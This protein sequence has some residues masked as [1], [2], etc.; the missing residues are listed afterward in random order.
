VERGMWDRSGA[1]SGIVFVV[2]FVIGFLIIG[3]FPDVGD[4][5]DKTVGYF[6]GHH[7]RILTAAT[8][9]GV[10]S[11]FFI[12]FIATLAA[13]LRRA[14]EPRLASTAYGGGIVFL[15]ILSADVILF[16]GL[17][18]SIAKTADADVTRALYSLH[19]PLSVLLVFP[20]ATLVFATSLAG[21]RTAVL[22]DWLSWLGLLA[23]IVFLAGGT[24]W[25]DDGFWAP[26]GVYQS[27]VTVIVFLAW[28]FM[29]SAVL[30]TRLPAEARTPRA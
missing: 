8:L 19:W 26:D 6:T 22:P 14:D 11:I 15:T 20:V 18:F 7:G 28:V 13:V 24:T 29:T 9:F 25:S 23:T 27:Y 5:A 17:T 16:A 12:W 21:L 3:N 1:S 10:A 4:S 2:L 30:A